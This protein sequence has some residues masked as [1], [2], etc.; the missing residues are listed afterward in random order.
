MKT[1]F[2]QTKLGVMAVSVQNSYLVELKLVAKMQDSQHTD[3]SLE[4]AK[5]IDEYLNK[6]RK[7]FDLPLKLNVSDFA[8]KVLAEVQKTPYA[9]TKSYKEIAQNIQNPKAFRAVGM[10]NN[11]NPLPIIIPCHR[12]IGSNGALVG[13]AYG[14]KI[15][16]YLLDLEKLNA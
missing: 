11:K 15:K 14:L 5:Q 3:L 2:Y 13:Y 4:C 8:Q 16:K 9:K 1:A 12:I 7:I 10:A 6:K